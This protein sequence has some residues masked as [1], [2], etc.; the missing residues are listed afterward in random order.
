MGEAQLANDD[1]AAAIARVREA[2]AQARIAGAALLPAISASASATRERE[3]SLSPATS[4]RG[5][6][7]VSPT[8]TVNEFSPLLNATYALDFW[9][10]NR[11]ALRSAEYA[12]DAS[13]YDR[14]TVELTVMTSVANSF[15]QAIEAQDRLTVA[16]DNLVSAEK[17]LKGL[18]FEQTVGIVTALD[19]A[20][21]ETQ[22]AIIN[23]SVPPLEQQL[24]QS[25][26]CARDPCRQGA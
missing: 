16:R 20:Q 14:V 3:L 21:Q 26:R 1:I 23:A 15:F 6:P 11:A 9:G 22:V 5:A 7:A 24:K 13:R 25:H 19:V 18:R 17:I 8:L 12:A 4:G 10:K 2:D